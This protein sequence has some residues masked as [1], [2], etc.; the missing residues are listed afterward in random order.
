LRRCLRNENP[1]KRV[2]MDRGQAFHKDSI[3]TG[4]WQL[5]VVAV[6]QTTSEQA[7]INLEIIA[8]Q[9]TF[10]DDFPNACSAKKKHVIGIAHQG[11]C[12]GG[13]FFWFIG[14]P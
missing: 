3:R 7:R 9:A 13:K 8:T 6:H 11:H 1:V 2:F 12:L 14:R 4:H 10:D 5:C